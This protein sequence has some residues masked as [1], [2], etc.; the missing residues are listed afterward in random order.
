MYS[1]IKF[2]ECNKWSKLSVCDFYRIILISIEP[3]ETFSIL[4]NLVISS[5]DVGGRRRELA[6]NNEN[7]KFFPNR[8]QDLDPLFWKPDY[9]SILPLHEDWLTTIFDYQIRPW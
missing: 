1:G 7:H 6:I 5:G 4:I 9:M 2:I 8:I 3:F